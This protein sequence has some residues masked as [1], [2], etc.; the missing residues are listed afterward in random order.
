MAHQMNNVTV[1]NNEAAHRFEATVDG[2]VA[3]AEYG[4][5]D[6][7]IVFTHTIVPPELEGRGLASKIVHTALDH[8]RAEHLSVVPLCPFVA[9]YLRRHPEYHEIVNPAYRSRVAS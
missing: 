4:R 2:H 3:F 6:D 8:A 9:S 1:T 5:V 7:D